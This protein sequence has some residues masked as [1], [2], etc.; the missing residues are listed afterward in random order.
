VEGV[1][2]NPINSLL[3]FHLWL[4]AP[5][6]MKINPKIEALGPGVRFREN[7]AI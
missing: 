1:E 2:F 5:I 6:G 4:A 3:N 7:L